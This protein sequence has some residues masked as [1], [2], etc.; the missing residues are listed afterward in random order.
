[1]KRCSAPLIIRKMQIKTTMRYHLTLVRM[2]I[3]QKSINTN[4]GCEEK[5]NLHCWEGKL[6]QPLWRT[7]WRFLR[8]LKIELPY[9]SVI[10]ILGVYLEK[11]II[12]KN[13]CSP[14]FIAALFTI[15]RTQTQPKSQSTEEWIKDVVRIDNG[16][17][18][19]KKK[20]EMT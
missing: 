1:M 3:I 14:V 9:H 5:G 4:R 2:A 20:N 19:V 11:I 8:N 7:V 15:A 13:T 12:Q 6:V 16:M 18:A 10:P 17:L